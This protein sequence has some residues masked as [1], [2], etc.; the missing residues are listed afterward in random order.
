MGRV[1]I[2]SQG[3]EEVSKRHDQFLRDIQNLWAEVK[4]QDTKIQDCRKQLGFGY[5]ADPYSF[6]GGRETEPVPGLAKKVE[7][8]CE[9]FGIHF[10]HHEE[11]W[12]AWSTAPTEKSNKD[13]KIVNLQ[14]KEVKK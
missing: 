12:S 9:Y 3:G 8:I 11:K 14:A 13:A 7:L 5:K 1:A 10:E 6:T 2:Q 4:H